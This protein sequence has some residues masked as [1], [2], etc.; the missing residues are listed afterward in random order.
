[1]KK[2]TAIVRIGLVGEVVHSIEHAGCRCLS[3]VNI[4][5]LG[6]LVDP[7]NP[8]ISFEYEGHYSTMSRIEVLCADE[9]VDRL[10]SI[11]KSIGHTDHPGDG[12]VYI[13]PVER[14]AKIQTGEEGERVLRAKDESLNA[15]SAKGTTQ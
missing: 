6:D 3:A 5:G 4:C 12:L 8:H 15:K 10:M 9:D 7:E 14:A 13:S 1:M 11:V 2:L